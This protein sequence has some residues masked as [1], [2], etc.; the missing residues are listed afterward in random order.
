MNTKDI[1]SEIIKSDILKIFVILF[2]FFTLLA[3]FRLYYQF[4]GMKIPELINLYYP[5]I[6][7]TDNVSN[8]IMRPWVFITHLGAEVSVLGMLTNFIWLYLFGFIIEDL[9]GKN[10]VWPLFIFSA[11]VCALV[12]CICVAINKSN[13]SSGFYYGMRASIISV[14]VA[15][16]VFRPKYK[17]FSMYN[18]GLSVWIIGLLFILLSVF[19]IPTLDV[20]NIAAIVTAIFIGYLYNNLFTEFFSTIQNKLNNRA[21]RNLNVNTKTKKPK[22]NSIQ[23]LSESTKVV[24]MS[25]HKMNTLLDKISSNGL[26]SLTD[27]EKK[28]LEDFSNKNN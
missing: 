7:L 27:I 11:I 14:C 24:D 13:L 23:V 12:V 9:K 28:W 18:G 20:A 5:Y 3:T 2:S 1:K 16:C 4:N 10:S 26:S 21:L 17:L 6:T 15:A 19:T 22:Y 8:N 25:N